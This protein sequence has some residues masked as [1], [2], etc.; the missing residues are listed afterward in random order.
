MG[1]KRN[2]SVKKKQAAKKNKLSSAFGV[3]VLQGGTIARTN[4]FLDIIPMAVVTS[5]GMKQKAATSTNYIGKTMKCDIANTNI[6]NS[7]RNS[8]T[9]QKNHHE[10]NE[11]DRLHASL[12]ERS[13]AL[14]ARK[15]D[16]LVNKKERRKQQKNGWGKFARPVQDKFAPATLNLDPKTTQELVDDA[17]NQVAMGMK[18]I[19]Q[20]AAINSFALLSAEPLPGQS[21]L[22][23]AAGMNWK[24]RDSTNQN[25]D[26][27]QTHNEKNPFAALNWGSDDDLDE[28][29]SKAA[30]SV[31]HLKFQPASFSFQSKITYPPP[32]GPLNNDFDPDL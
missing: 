4:G 14:Q 1:K 23:A 12:E 30:K 22:A 6:G 29:Y 7:Q 5:K 32:T 10:Q 15:N 9:P 19:G 11:F 26:T 20:R 25:G 28:N 3:S 21:S 13:L 16:Q 31:P 24:Q 2:N 27:K 17:A 18:E 8:S